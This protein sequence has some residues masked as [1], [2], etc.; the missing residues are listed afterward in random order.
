MKRCITNDEI[1][2]IAEGWRSEPEDGDDHWLN[3][4]YLKEMKAVNQLTATS[5]A[6]VLV[7][8]AVWVI[9]IAS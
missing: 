2:A 8:L 7:I 4:V 5:S 9:G 1:E 3:E 6:L